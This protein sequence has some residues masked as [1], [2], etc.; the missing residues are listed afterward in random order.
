MLERTDR[1]QSVLD[2]G[3]EIDGRRMSART[4]RRLVRARWR[5]FEHA[6]NKIRDLHHKA[7]KW[8]TDTFRVILLPKFKTST[9]VTGAGKLWSKTCRKLL[10]WSH[11]RFRQRLMEHAHR[12]GVRV[13]LVN[14]A[15]ST[16]TCGNCGLFV[17]KRR[18]TVQCTH[19][20]APERD[21]DV[22]GARNVLLRFLEMLRR[23]EYWKD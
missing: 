21:R 1:Y 3:V 19:C 15:Y 12:K 16:L 14:E 8:L 5:L 11:Y 10:T 20:D 13:W 17:E 18:E 6:R 9:M 4:R 2:G 7:A 22:A 23:I